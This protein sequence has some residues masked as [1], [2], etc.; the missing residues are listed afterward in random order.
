MSKEQETQEASDDTTAAFGEYLQLRLGLSASVIIGYAQSGEVAFSVRGTDG[1]L[2]GLL[3]ALL[4]MAPPT[5]QKE[6][7][8]RQISASVL[9][10]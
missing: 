4:Q 6:I 3:I 8:R 9:G 10:D 1:E 7:V 2:A 5:V